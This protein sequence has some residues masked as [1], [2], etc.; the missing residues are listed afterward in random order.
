M[1]LPASAPEVRRPAALSWSALRLLP[2]LLWVPLIAVL[3]ATITVTVIEER[4]ASRARASSEGIA[5][6]LGRLDALADINTLVANMESAERGYMLTHDEAYLNQFT[7]AQRRLPTEQT[8]LRELS[9]GMPG[10]ITW[11]ERI[12]TLTAQYAQL[13]QRVITAHR[14]G[15]VEEALTL[16]RGEEGRSIREAFAKEVATAEALS[17]QELGELQ[18]QQAT[19]AYWARLGLLMITPVTVALLIILAAVF[20]SE[21]LRQQQRVASAERQAKEL[22]RVVD[23]R[24]RELSSLSTHLQEFTEKEKSEL[25]HHLHDEL[26]GLLTAAKMDLSWLQS[27]IDQPGIPERM[28]QLGAMLDEAMDLKRNVVENLRPSLLEHFGLPTAAKAYFEATAKK[29]GLQSEV[30]IGNDTESL[31]KDV[32]IALF[33]VVQEGLANVIAHAHATSVRLAITRLGNRYLLILSD[34]GRG[35]S[36]AQGMTG[37]GLVGLRHRMRALGGTLNIESGEGEGT[38]LRVE[39]PDRI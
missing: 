16:L 18:S 3:L 27:R 10:G 29:A 39:V 13:A 17:Q 9:V 36:A 7:D 6:V 15:N 21:A 25:A 4:S 19:G 37:H 26:G 22:E 28:T 12:E 32:A 24:T 33:R 2:P 35:M 20:A 1:D 23:E 38:T 8:R 30:L 5:N 34:D 11:V 14:D 31:P